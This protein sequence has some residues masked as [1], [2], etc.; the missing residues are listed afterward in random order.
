MLGKLFLCWRTSDLYKSARNFYS[1][2]RRNIRFLIHRLASF[3]DIENRR[4]LENFTTSI[5][6]SY[7]F[8][9]Q[10]CQNDFAEKRFSLEM[11]SNN[12]SRN[13]MKIL[14]FML[15]EEQSQVGRK[16]NFDKSPR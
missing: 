3:R 6:E 11:R 14:R 12:L 1:R 10:L 7:F 8:H 5:V 16:L 9:Q 15:Y 2:K 4:R 13:N